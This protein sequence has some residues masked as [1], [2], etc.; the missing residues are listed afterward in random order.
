M[1]N[2]TANDRPEN[3]GIL[4]GILSTALLVGTYREISTEADLLWDRGQGSLRHTEPEHKNS[5]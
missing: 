2:K 4:N 5:I 1:W 3:L